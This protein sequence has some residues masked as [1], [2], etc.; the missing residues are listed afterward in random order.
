MPSH[1]ETGSSLAEGFT[2]RQIFILEGR[3]DYRSGLASTVQTEVV[4]STPRRGLNELQ[5]ARTFSRWSTSDWVGGAAHRGLQVEMGH[6]P[7]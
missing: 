7:R 2:R 6:G 1:S 3:T 4:S 5:L